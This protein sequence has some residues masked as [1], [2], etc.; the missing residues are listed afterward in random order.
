MGLAERMLEAGERLFLPQASAAEAEWA[1]GLATQLGAGVEILP[2]LD[3][4]SL[5]PRMAYAKGVI[6]VDSGLG[7]LAVGLNLPTVQLFSQDR[8]RRAGP[9]GQPHQRA[10]GGD[11]VPT[12]EEVWRAWLDS[13]A[14]ETYG[15]PEIGS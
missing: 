12:V 9:V 4:G 13:W 3:L 2:R 7:H 8:I 6:S 5:W 10:V 15:S 1:E 14:V 11:H